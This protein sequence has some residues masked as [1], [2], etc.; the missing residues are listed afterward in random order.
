MGNYLKCWDSL[1]WLRNP[2]AH[3]HVDEQPSL[4]LAGPHPRSSVIIASAP[5]LL[6]VVSC[7]EFLWH[8]HAHHACYMSHP[9]HFTYYNNPYS[10]RN[11]LAFST[12][13]LFLQHV[14]LRYSQSVSDPEG[15]E[16]PITAVPWYKA[17]NVLVLQDTGIVGSNFSRGTDIC[18]HF[19]CPCASLRR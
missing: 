7:L 4:G 16:H 10:F 8:Y 5:W 6:H 1:S 19:F 15:R 2:E 3:N 11:S 9:S 14:I 17:R 13:F 18:L 12:N